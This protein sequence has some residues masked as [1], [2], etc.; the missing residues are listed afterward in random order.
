M[1]II[2]KKIILWILLVILIS[3]MIGITYYVFVVSPDETLNN[4]KEQDN[5]V[6]YVGKTKVVPWSTYWVEKKENDKTI[7]SAVDNTYIFNLGEKVIILCSFKSTECV[8]FHYK[9]NDKEYVVIDENVNLL[10]ENLKFFDDVDEDGNPIIKINK[11]W[12]DGAISVFY[13]KKNV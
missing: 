13:L 11:Y 6:E 10:N 3:M 5:G 8:T 7:D 2:M 12:D 1:I 9:K 4:S